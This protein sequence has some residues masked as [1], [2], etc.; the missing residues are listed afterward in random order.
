MDAKHDEQRQ[1]DSLRVID[2]TLSASAPKLCPRITTM[3]HPA[4]ASTLAS[5]LTAVLLVL[6]CF[7]VQ[8]TRAISRSLAGT[9]DWHNRLIG[10]IRSA[11]F[12]VT[13][14]SAKTTN[15][16]SREVIVT[17]SKAPS[18]EDVIATLDAQTGQVIWSQVVGD[19]QDPSSVSYHVADDAVYIIS[20]SKSPVIHSFSL[21]TGH[22]IWQTPIPSAYR[23]QQTRQQP[24]SGDNGAQIVSA[25]AS[26]ILALVGDKVIKLDKQTG[27]VQW[28]WFDTLADQSTC[29]PSHIEV[30]NE[31]RAYL[32]AVIN[33][34]ASPQ[35]GM[36]TLDL[37]NGTPIGDKHIKPLPANIALPTDYLVIPA[38]TDRL[39]PTLVW[40]DAQSQKVASV[41][42]DD[43]AK[44]GKASLS[45]KGGY[46]SISDIGLLQRGVVLAQ[47]ETGSDVLEI[48]P[49]NIKVSTSFLPSDLVGCSQNGAGALKVNVPATLTSNA[50]RKGLKSIQSIVSDVRMFY[51]E[52]GSVQGWKDGK[53]LWDREEALNDILATVV[54]ELPEDK[55]GRDAIVGA[56]QDDE[57]FLARSQRHLKQLIVSLL[58]ILERGAIRRC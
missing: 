29:S 20:G 31:S 10:P 4:L 16:S 41:D 6:A 56:L 13:Q 43:R 9:I 48:S 57:G 12:A 54:V 15:G 11:Q 32:V 55:L 5:L 18:Q 51:N 19:V 37:E 26:S 45:P 52:K 50:A 58:V 49:S 33:S 46:K 34:V 27:N 3:R 25:D 38:S 42:I 35:L 53:L 22:A 28:T 1:L 30:V 23:Q 44:P 14:S 7:G 17:T 40:L 39:N 36:V 21:G 2:R 47:H 24:D 8:E